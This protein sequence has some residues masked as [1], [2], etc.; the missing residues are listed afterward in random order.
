VKIIYISIKLTKRKPK[1]RKSQ[2]ITGVGTGDA[3]SIGKWLKSENKGPKSCFSSV[4]MLY[5]D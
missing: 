2:P 4:D 3:G 1:K 5:K